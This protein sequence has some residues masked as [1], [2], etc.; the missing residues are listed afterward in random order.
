VEHKLKDIEQI[1]HAALEKDQG[2]ERCAYLDSV[3]GENIALRVQ[4]ED[5]LKANEEAGNFL[6]IPG[7]SDDVTLSDSP[8]TEGPGTKIGRYKLLEKIGEGGM[9][10]VYMAEQEKPI[11][12]KV[13]LKII[14]L[15]MDTRQVIARF[16][17]ERQALAMMDHPNIAKVLDAGATETGRPYFV[18]ELV[19]GVSITEYCDGSELST[20]ERLD[21][22]LQVCNAVQHA[23]QKGIIHR[24]IKPSNVM[25]TQRDGKPVPKVIDFGIAKATNRRLTEKTLFTR[26]A[27]IIGTPAYMSPEQAELSELDVDTRTDIYSL[28]VLLYELLTGT[29]PFSEE[30]LRKAGYVEMQR[31]IREEEPTKPSTKL[32]TLGE[33]LTDVAM[34]RSS[35]PE[36][37]RKTIRGDLDWI[38]MKSLEK[39]RARR[40][41]TASELAM[42]IE[43]HLDDEPVLA[44]PPGAVYRLR[45]FVRR[46]RVGVMTG[47][48]IAAALLVVALVSAMYAVK[49]E[50]AK[51]EIS[52]L[53]AESYVDRAQALCEQGEV[54]RG[55]LWLA[56]TLKIAPAGTNDLGHAVRTSLVAWHNQLHSLRVV[57]KYPDRIRQI[58]FSSDG[59]LML[60]AC[61]DGTARLCDGATGQ[62]IGSPLHH[63]SE[64]WAV[65][66]SPDGTRMATR[67]TDDSLCLWD[68]VT[69]KPVGEPMQHK[70]WSRGRLMEFSSDSSRLITGGTDGAVRLWD[71]DTGKSLGKAFQYEGK[72]MRSVQA[73]ACCPEGLRVVVR[74]GEQI[75][76]MFDDDRGE[77]IGPPVETGSRA[78]V[79]AISPD[80]KRFATAKAHSLIQVWEAATGR[81]VYEP[82]VHGGRIYALAFSPDGSRIVSGGNTRIALLWDA[83][84]GE[85]IG[86]PLRQRNTVHAAAFSPDGALVVTGNQDGVVRVWDLI[87]NKYIGEPVTHEARILA[88][89]YGPDSLRIL[90]EADGAVQVR[91][92]ATGMPIGKPVSEPNKIYKDVA[93]SPDGTRLLT[94][95]LRLWDITTG[96]LLG[97]LV[98]ESSF[99]ATGKAFSPDGS[100]I[101]SGGGDGVVRVWDA[102]TLECLGEFLLHGGY[103]SRT[104]FSPDGSQFL[105]GSYDGTTQL[106]D[107]ATLEPIGKL[108]VHQSEV[109]GLTFSPDGTR[110][111]IGFAD[112]TVRL[113]D[114]ATLMPIGTPLQQVKVVCSVAFSPDSS[115]FLACC[116]HRTARL[117]DTATLKP[118]GP[119]LEHDGWWPKVS[120]SP[121]GSEILLT[122]NFGTHA[123]WQAP[124]G[125]LTGDCEQIICWVQVVTG[126]EL[127]PTGGINVLDTPTWQKRRQRLK[128]LGGPP[129]LTLSGL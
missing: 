77:P 25:V 31:I 43:K 69:L 92:A 87:Q 97:E 29:T 35:T 17:A 70:K 72:S 8:L 1:Y 54:G 107:A 64:V 9:A 16:E 13:A 26:Y 6:E 114:A 88:T 75:Y 27:H 115:Q 65:A 123:I 42:D 128:G 94:T 37:L 21:L 79:V 50:K 14:K 44:G 28:G 80:G 23:H 48:L 112:G 39:N 113:R 119:P 110:I 51:Q 116:M 19:K 5:L 101:V 7:F 38:V 122:D 82:I 78:T 20:C 52:S 61:R 106:W 36:L 2:Q 118:I 24:D 4:I 60:A 105:T 96:E 120:F 121:N 49:A 83:A 124:P 89:A 68:A 126:L 53:L 125:P 129:E 102:A 100:L 99:Q 47:L 84:T 104:A 90:T 103:V 34:H 81:L 18:M 117:W 15:G 63:G 33:T 58:T 91:N 95:S 98:G 62:P 59:T 74:I 12:R 46:N 32:S 55:M 93:F 56:D 86:G 30:E 111:L 40:Y 66:I 127:D 71:A 22:F 108:L 67:G 85:P 41:E 57:V 10:V 76:Q 11:R 3:C 45:K 109:K 73:V